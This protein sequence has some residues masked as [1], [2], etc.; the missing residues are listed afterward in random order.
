MCL[1]VCL[2]SIG[3][4]M[5]SLC[6]ICQ[7]FFIRDLLD[8]EM[9]Q[10]ILHHRSLDSLERSAVDCSLCKLF[11]GDVKITIDRYKETHKSNTTTEEIIW[12]TSP[13]IIRGIPSFANDDYDVVPNQVKIIGFKLRLG[14][15]DLPEDLKTYWYYSVY[16]DNPDDESVAGIRDLIP[17]RK[18]ALPQEAS[19]LVRGWIDD[20]ERN[21]SICRRPPGPLP[22]RVLDVGRDGDDPRLLEA[23]GRV[24]LYITLSHCW[25]PNPG[26]V[27]RTER[28][29]IEDHLQRIPISRLSNTF[30]SA[31]QIT[32]SLGIRYLWIDSLC[33]V[34]DDEADWERESA[35]MGD[36]YAQAF[37]TIA[38]AG[39]PVPHV[40][41]FI[42]RTLAGHV[43]V[44]FSKKSPA[45]VL[46]RPRPRGFNK[47]RESPLQ[48]RAW[49]AQER[50]LSR[51]TI[52]YDI[53]QVLFECDGS[54]A[55]EDCVPVEEYAEA[56]AWAKFR[57]AY[58]AKDGHPG[59]DFIWDW[60]E[61]VED[62][63][64]RALTQGS[65]K[66]PAVSGIA[67]IMERKTGESYVA[68]LWRSHLEFGLLWSRNPTN[69]LTPPPPECGFRAPSWSWASLDGEIQ[70][71]NLSRSDAFECTV[72][73][74]K[75]EST[76]LGL[77]PHGRLASGV[78]TL[79][80][81]VKAIDPRIDP[82]SPEWN[83][84]PVF[85]RNRAAEPGDILTYEG[86]AI[87]EGYFDR[88][89]EH[90]HQARPLYCLEV[91]RRVSHR[92]RWYGLILESS[93]KPGEF[94]RVGYGRDIGDT[95]AHS[96][97]EW[98]ADVEPRSISIL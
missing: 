40:G 85:S 45:R 89:F 94:R 63:T 46:V 68:G 92:H 44:P 49:V 62:Y 73:K 55:T 12:R 78:L 48:R 64:A 52:H 82:Q 70:M 2:T 65:D 32:R 91:L 79:I 81:R 22:T 23:S 9:P 16:L 34:Q 47:L 60:Y 20:C 93:G 41:C 42:P 53:D 67:K 39:S 50:A 19:A 90:S 37:A 26:G 61:M 75:A 36:I 35:K 8:D 1:N 30:A 84:A 4:Q 24:A 56:K 54:K 97:G 25:G 86:Q 14:S 69:W 10:D 31:V 15:L 11:F 18:I 33:I 21:H 43:S 71:E 87:G 58:E 13:L 98:L 5:M 38:A 17:G 6:S 28:A 76:P 72:E 74:M 66:L 96:Y 7:S 29:T 3:Y 59:G 77:D 80:G 88:Q 27:I 95:L 83:A 57:P 51:R